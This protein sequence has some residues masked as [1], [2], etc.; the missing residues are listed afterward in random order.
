MRKKAQE[1]SANVII[2]AIIALVVLVVLVAIFTGRIGSFNRAVQDCQSIENTECAYQ[3]GE[4]PGS[5]VK[6]PTAKCFVP[7]TSDVDEALVCCQRLIG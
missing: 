1:I 3:C 7:G 4:L 6:H 2:I 5:Y